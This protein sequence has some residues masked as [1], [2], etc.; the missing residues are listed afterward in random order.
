M[1]RNKSKG[2]AKESDVGSV[3]SWPCPLHPTHS[4]SISNNSLSPKATTTLALLAFCFCASFAFVY[5]CSFCSL[6][7]PLPYAAGITLSIP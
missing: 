2:K 3:L 6:L 5:V 1:K 4:H 7:S